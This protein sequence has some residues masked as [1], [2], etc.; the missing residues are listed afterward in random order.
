MQKMIC[1]VPGYPNYQI[2]VEGRVLS[3]RTGK[4]MAQVENHAG[5]KCVGLSNQ[6]GRKQMKV[7]RLVLMAFSP[8]ED[9]GRLQVNHKDAN[10]QN[11]TL[12][13]LEWCTGLEN[14]RHAIANGLKDYDQHGEKNNCHK[15]TLEDVIFI[16]T[17]ENE[18]SNREFAEMFNV[19]PSN[20]HCV[21]RRKSWQ[22]F[23]TERSLH[24]E[25]GD[26]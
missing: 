3:K 21:R 13:N 18:Y 5:Y 14:T 25:K 15:L 7:H 23:D 12:G 26:I 2:T 1:D 24:R 11:N 20:I 19:T 6:N 4:E 10:K 9:M 17:H 8:V 22:G 16:R